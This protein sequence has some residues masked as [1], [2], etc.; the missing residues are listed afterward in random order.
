MHVCTCSITKMRISISATIT[1]IHNHH[2]DHHHHHHHHQLA[3]QSCGAA[4]ENEPVA[5]NNLDTKEVL[6]KTYRPPRNTVSRIPASAKLRFMSSRE[7]KTTSPVERSKLSSA[8]CSC[9]AI[10]LFRS[11]TLTLDT[12]S[13][14]ILNSE[15]SIL[16]TVITLVDT[17][18]DDDACDMATA[19]M[20]DRR[21]RARCAK[22]PKLSSD[23]R[24]CDS[25]FSSEAS[26]IAC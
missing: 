13:V 25:Q 22:Q 10:D 7:L 26:L 14:L 2:H 20:T 19:A 21:S 6:P 12:F 3:G 1:Y 5:Y 17:S 11:V 18:R 16:K 9:M 4:A 24:S 15:P 23:R 8:M